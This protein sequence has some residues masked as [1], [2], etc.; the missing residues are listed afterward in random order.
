MGAAE[1]ALAS[2]K[3]RMA[4]G[5][6]RRAAEKAILLIG[7]AASDERS[8]R[9]GSGF[10]N[11]GRGWGEIARSGGVM[12]ERYRSQRQRGDGGALSLS[13]ACV[14]PASPLA[15]ASLRMRRDFV[16]EG[17]DLLLEVCDGV[18]LTLRVQLAAIGL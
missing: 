11:E 14:T 16:I 5:E 1:A 18:Y 3:S 17:R 10:P 12:E 15:T 7:R 4:V 9:S 8:P 2:T 6:K 13:I